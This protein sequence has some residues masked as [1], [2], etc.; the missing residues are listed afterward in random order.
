MS[1]CPQV[2]H[3]KSSPCHERSMSESPTHS[4]ISNVIIM[5]KCK[6]LSEPPVSLGRPVSEL[7]ELPVRSTPHFSSVVL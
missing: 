1:S 2:N 7:C 5:S 3:R 6:L 4:T